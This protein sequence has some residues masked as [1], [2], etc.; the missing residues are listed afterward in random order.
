MSSDY[1]LQVEPGLPVRCP[2]FAL[3][4][5]HIVER[6][7]ELDIALAELGAELREKWKGVELNRIT[8][9][10]PVREIYRAIGLDPTRH[11]P[12]SEALLRRVLKG[13]LL[14]R[15]N[16]LVDALNY[17]SL[18]YL[19][20]YGLYDLEKIQPPVSLRRGR[21]GEGY[22]GIRKEFV[23]VAD[24]LC[25]ADAAGPFGNPSSDADRTK[26]TTATTRALVV[27]FLPPAMGEE[28]VKGLV[29]ETARILRRFSEG[30]VRQ[31]F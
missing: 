17:C 20:P 23:N 19:V 24:R 9:I 11:R 5:L 15:V 4:G 27:P 29:E 6:F 13:E 12:S 16:T 31:A 18:K 28:V 30:E 10:Q 8:G 14:Y 2:A 21:E 22:P 25:L 26:I 3:E 1:P 7:P